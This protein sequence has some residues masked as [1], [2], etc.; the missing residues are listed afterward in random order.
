M[1]SSEISPPGAGDAAAALAQQAGDLARLVDA[2]LA[3]SDASG[4][5]EEAIQRGLTALVKLY[6]ARWEAG[7][8]FAPVLPNDGVSATAALILVTA[9]L[10]AVH[11]ELFELGM[12]QAWSGR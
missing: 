10:Q 8:R 3:Q 1:P 2:M 7:A 11:V 5:P 12:W 9:L 4:V 6:A